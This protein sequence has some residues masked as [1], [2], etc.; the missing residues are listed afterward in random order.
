MTRPTIQALIEDGPRAG[1]TVQ[2]DVAQEG[3]PPNEFLLGDEHFGG[4][5]AEPRD[6]PSGAVSIYHLVGRD[7]ERGGYVYR[8]APQGG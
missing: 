2:L 5:A 7:D 6:T 3:Q 8:L 1:E 4:R